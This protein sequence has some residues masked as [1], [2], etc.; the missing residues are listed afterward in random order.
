MSTISEILTQERTVCCVP[1]VSKKRLFEDIARIACDDQRSMSYDD[2]L[3]RLIAR[4]KLGST[5]VGGGIAIP[6]SRVTRCASPVGVLIS[7][8]E[9]IPFD[10]PDEMPV[11]LLFTL[12]VPEEAHQQHL[13]ILAAIAQLFS[14]PTFCEELRKASNSRA[15]YELICRQAET[16]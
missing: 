10:A 14:V 1:R 11:D 2:V 7:L 9:P 4:E 8:E 12:L 13:D 6:H 15:L 5:A 16:S 3:D